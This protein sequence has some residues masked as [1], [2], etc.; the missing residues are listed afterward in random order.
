MAWLNRWLKDDASAPT[1]AAPVRA[2]MAGANRWA[3][4]PAVPVAGRDPSRAL[5]LGGGSANTLSGDGVLADSAGAEGVD[6]FTYDPA[7]PVISRGGEIGG[8][9]LDQEGNDGAYDQRG[10]EAR[11][12]VLVYTSAPLAEDLAVFGYVEV[13]LFVGSDRPDTDFTVKLVDVAPDGTAW[14]ISDS[15][16]RMRYRE[17][18]ASQVFMTPGETYRIKPPPMLAANVFLKGHRVRLEVSSSN[19]PTYARNLNTAGDPYTTSETAIARNEVRHGGAT[20][21]RVVL[22]VVRLPEPVD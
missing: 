3:E 22:P 7:D 12:D 18:E 21:A 19:F 2:Y 5:F 17:G 15:I 11:Q 4:F 14:N 16:Q 1:P 8:V 6:V 10:I 9:G 20:P 13:E